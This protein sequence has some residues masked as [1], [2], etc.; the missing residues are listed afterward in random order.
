M[1]SEDAPFV[2]TCPIC[3][4]D[5]VSSEARTCP[6]CG[7]PDVGALIKAQRSR[8]REEWCRQEPQRLAQALLQAEHA[9]VQGEAERRIKDAAAKHV[10]ELA[11]FYSALGGAGMGLLLFFV[12]GVF[13]TQLI[14][15]FGPDARPHPGIY[16]MVL[17]GFIGLSALF[18]W[19]LAIDRKG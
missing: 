9:R 8:D 16:L 1:N 10:R 3:G 14:T 2:G 12:F 18:G 7:H 5:N 4:R 17:G 13:V 11:P 19:I 6:R 15:G